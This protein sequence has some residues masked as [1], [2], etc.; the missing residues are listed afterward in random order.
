MRPSVFF[1]VVGSGVGG[2]TALTTAFFSFPGSSTFLSLPIDHIALCSFFFLAAIGAPPSLTSSSS[3]PHSSL[4]ITLLLCTLRSFA[5]AAAAAAVAFEVPPP[6][7][8]R[9]W[10]RRPGEGKPFDHS[11]T[12]GSPC[13][14]MRYA[15]SVRSEQ[16]RPLLPFSPSCLPRHHNS[17]LVPIKNVKGEK[18]K[19]RVTASFSFYS[20]CIPRR[21]QGL[22]PLLSPLIAA[23]GLSS[24]AV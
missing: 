14:S 9:L 5:A 18:E 16:E 1:L 24:L 3:P 19:K 15:R 6:P 12:W 2:G 11:S 21:C 22:S 13:P 4:K 23:G 7:P 10:R 20:F 8:V 17:I